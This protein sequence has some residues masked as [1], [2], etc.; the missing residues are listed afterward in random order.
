MEDKELFTRIL[1]LH[2]PWFIK[3]VVVNDSEQRIDIYLEHEPGIKVRCPECGVFH[4]LYDHA[5]ERVYRH[6]SVCQMETYIHVRSPRVNCPQ[7]GVKQI[8][9]ELGENGSEMTIAFE[10]FVIRVARECSIEATARLC[11]VSWDQG[12]NVLERA[13]TRGRGRKPHRIPCRIG[14]DEKSIARGHKYESLVYDLDGGTVEFVCDDRGQESLEAYYRQ[15]SREEL[16]GVQA[17]AMDMWDPYIAATRA[18]VPEAERKIVF[19]RFHVMK[20]VLEAVDEVRK[21]EHRQL[22][23]RG[24]P[25]LKGTKYLWLWSRENIPL[26]R[27][28]EFETLRARDLKVCRAW[29]IKENLRHLWDYRYEGSMRSYF[30]RWYFWVTHSR[31]EPM[32]K[33]AKTLKVHVENIVTYA[34]HRITNALGEAINAKI[35]KVKRM[36]CGFRNRKNYRTAIYFHCGGLDLFPRPPLQ[37]TLSFQLGPQPQYIGGTH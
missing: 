37:P 24:E 14:V 25:L 17:V 3:R 15:F 19:D 32:K 10:S 22:M 35:E 23:S 6:L 34:R 28:E 8:D 21:G 33:A 5:P 16:A 4:G 20:H 29:A 7:H 30:K 27:R 31:L 11:G 9:S 2:P 26:W 36:A 1:G 12:W 13:V 18:H